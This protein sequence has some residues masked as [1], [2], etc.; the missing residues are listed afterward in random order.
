MENEAHRAVVTGNVLS[1]FFLTFSMALINSI[2]HG[3][4]VKTEECFCL[5][6]KKEVLGFAKKMVWGLG[7]GVG[8][9][10][11]IPAKA[12]KNSMVVCYWACFKLF[13]KR[14]RMRSIDPGLLC[15][16]LYQ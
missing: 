13:C 3:G 4:A 10:W 11:G 12:Y 15:L 1:N 16:W 7:L 2:K 8:W 9:Q 14:K 5:E 6:L